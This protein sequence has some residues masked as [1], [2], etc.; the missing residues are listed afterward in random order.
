VAPDEGAHEGALVSKLFKLRSWLNLDEAAQYLSV[1]FAEEVRKADILR[2]AL[3]GQLKL[4]VRLV[5][6]ACARVLERIPED[7]VQASDVTFI[8][9]HGWLMKPRPSVIELEADPYELS[10][11]GGESDDVEHAYQL[12]TGGPDV[13]EKMW[14]GAYLTD[15]VTY[16]QLLD[17]FENNRHFSKD[18][19]KKPW[20]HPDN[21]YPAG[22]LPKDAV[23]VVRTTELARFQAKL[24]EADNKLS[25]ASTPLDPR[26]ETTYLTII[27][28]LLELVRTPRPGRDSDAAVI[29]ELIDN[30]GDKPGISKTTLEAKFADARRRL[31]ST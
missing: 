28:A 30:Y 17:H 1:A 14:S 13:D 19:L 4:S 26:A 8:H 25:K 9:P 2:L 23:F 27:G 6:G 18:K 11:L 10:M 20:R 7:G 31:R 24:S 16:F 15:G 21:F 12:L 5:N 3:D 29:R 22:G